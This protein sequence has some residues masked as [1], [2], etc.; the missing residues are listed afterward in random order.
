MLKTVKIPEE[1]WRKVKVAAAENG[2]CML[3][4]LMEAIDLWLIKKKETRKK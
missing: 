1:Y 2:L 3:T 4:V